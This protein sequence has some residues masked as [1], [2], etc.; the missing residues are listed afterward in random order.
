ML[1][2]M[3]KKRVPA[4]AATI[5]AFLTGALNSFLLNGTK[6]PLIRL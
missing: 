6:H 2:V 1:L 4:P 3:G 5:T